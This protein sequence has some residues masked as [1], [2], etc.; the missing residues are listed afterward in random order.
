MTYQ[1]GRSRLR[2]WTALSLSLALALTGLGA[3]EAQ[4]PKP[5]ALVVVDIKAVA[6]GYRVSELRGRP[7]TNGKETIGK[8]DDLIIGRDKVLFAILSVGGFLGLGA[9]LV[10]VPYSSLRITPKAILLPGATDPAL[11]KL[12]EFKYR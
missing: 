4:A 5:V 1:F 2:R 8:I 12:P 9:H 11:R 3:A 6:L 10:A 7:V